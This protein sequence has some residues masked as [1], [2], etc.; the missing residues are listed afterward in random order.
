MTLPPT[1]LPFLDIET[2]LQT[3]EPRERWGGFRLFA[4]GMTIAVLLG[5]F[6]T[7]QKASGAGYSV[8]ASVVLAGVV[9]SWALSNVLNN[10]A[11]RREHQ[12]LEAIEE[13][14]QL[15][16]WPQA[17]FMVQSFLSRPAQ[18]HA[19]RAQALLFLAMVLSRYHRFEDS[20]AVHDYLL[21]DIPL[22]D[23]AA[24]SV[25]L[26]RAMAL[27]REENLLDADRAIAE[28]RRDTRG[29]G[30]SGA[31]TAGLALV[32]IYRDVKTGHPVEAAEM[33]EERLPL[34]RKHLGHRIADAWGLVARAYDMQGQ[35]EKAATAFQ[36]ATLLVPLGELKRRYPEIGALSPKFTAAAA[37]PEMA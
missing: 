17:A 28:L 21:Q 25:R 36:N 1:D 35:A 11:A 29:G 3:S 4:G 31:G 27:L 19:A 15:R 6:F 2:L 37:P 10:R 7:D 23:S 30:I 16:R 18:S 26:G 22:D 24:Y 5:W 14:L 8:F 32:E 9:A 13:L 33:F 12:T 34:I 20:V